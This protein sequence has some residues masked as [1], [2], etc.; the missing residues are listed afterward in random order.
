MARERIDLRVSMFGGS[1]ASISE[2]MLF[3]QVRSQPTGGAEYLVVCPNAAEGASAWRGVT[4]LSAADV[5]GLL[6]RLGSAGLP[7]RVPRVVANESLLADGPLL[8]MALRAGRFARSF[9]L[10]LRGAGFSGA[11]ASPLREVLISLADLT[12]IGRRGLVREMMDR[13]LGERRS[14]RIG[15]AP[16]AQAVVPL[17]AGTGLNLIGWNLP[18]PTAW[19]PES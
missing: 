11:D 13:A 19:E 15:P 3:A 7:G 16:M 1:I 10:L 4:E 5:E 14:G 18:R 6:D 12:P 8:A 2:L 17:G 9:D